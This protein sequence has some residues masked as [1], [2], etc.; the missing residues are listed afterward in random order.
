FFVFASKYYQ[1]G[2]TPEIW[3]EVDNIFK[4]YFGENYFYP[5]FLFNWIHAMPFNKPVDMIANSANTQESK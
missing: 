2:I 4:K 3:R 5:A 1:N